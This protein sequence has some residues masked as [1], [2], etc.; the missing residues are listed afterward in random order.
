[1]PFRGSITGFGYGRWQ[2]GNV[3][4]NNTGTAQWAAMFDSTG[5]DDLRAMVCDASNN[6][7]VAGVS[8]P[9][10]VSGTRIFDASGTTQVPSGFFVPRR[11]GVAY[12]TN[13]GL[14]AKYN[15]NGNCQWVCAIDAS[16]VTTTTD[17]IWN[18]A[19]DSEQN[20]Y[21]VGGAG[22]NTNLWDASGFT[23]TLSPV[24][25]QRQR[26]GFLCKVNPSGQFQWATGIGLLSGTLVSEA[27]LITIDT[28][29]NIYYG[30]FYAQ[31]GTG[32]ITLMDASGTTQSNS[33]YSIPQ[34]NNAIWWALLKM[35]SEGKIQWATYVPG[36][37][38]Q[39]VT[40]NGVAT[41]VNN[42]IYFA[43]TYNANITIPDVSGFTQSNSLY[44]LPA[45]IQTAGLI[46]YNSNGKV[47]WCVDLG[48]AAADESRSVAVD[49]QCNIYWVGTYRSNSL[50]SLV[51]RDA[52]GTGQINSLITIR[53]TGATADGA[54][55]LIKYNPDGK[56][57][58]ATCIDQTIANAD[59]VA[60]TIKIDS[61][62]NVYISGRTNCN[63]TCIIYDAS[64]N[65]QQASDISIV[66]P[67]ATGQCAFLVKYNSNGIG[68]WAT[69]IN[70]TNNCNDV[71]YGLALDRSNS[72]Y[73]GGGTIVTLTVRDVSGTTQKNSAITITPVNATS[74]N[75]SFIKYR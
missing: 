4:Y 43:M 3:Y 50:G 52:N 24:T 33:L 26:I 64:I 46:K 57:Q 17:N 39:D 73:V 40:L 30:G 19:I 9:G 27:N 34:T 25:L 13:L 10:D 70:G 66:V 60:T 16:G 47:Q 65:T 38:G 62:D 23:T 44:T 59:D 68:Q 61:I 22:A 55:F 37:S 12:T 20:I 6:L 8:Q 31:G 67:I 51:V 7:Y 11:T 32:R 69:N 5:L 58:W 35:N 75:A 15:S 42:N 2:T 14:L 48:G 72:L 71:W 63:A 21:V 45:N 54:V 18:S 53:N 74:S 29:N 49:S 56:A 1:M 28:Q 36:V 41:D